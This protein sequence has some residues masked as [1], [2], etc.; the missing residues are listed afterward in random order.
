MSVFTNYCA[1][2]LLWPIVTNLDINVNIICYMFN[3]FNWLIDVN[4][5][6]LRVHFLYVRNLFGKFLLFI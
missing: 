5:Q 6:R 1:P 2:Y 3:R 4:P